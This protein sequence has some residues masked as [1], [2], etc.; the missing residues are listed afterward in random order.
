MQSQ[1]AVFIAGIADEF[2]YAS[3][4][5]LFYLGPDGQ[6]EVVSP[7]SNMKGI[8]K[9]PLTGATAPDYINID[10]VDTTATSVFIDLET[11]I[12]GHL[13]LWRLSALYGAQLLGTANRLNSRPEILSDVGVLGN[14]S[15]FAYYDP[16]IPGEINELARLGPDGQVELVDI[17]PRVSGLQTLN[18]G[19]GHSN[20]RDFIEFAGRLWFV[21]DTARGGNQL[22]SIDSQGTVEPFDRDPA[23]ANIQPYF[24]L[25]ERSFV[26]NDELFLRPKTGTDSIAIDADGN[27]RKTPLLG[28]TRDEQ[29]F[30][31]HPDTQTVDFAGS[32][33]FAGTLIELDKNNRALLVDGDPETDGVQRLH[34]QE[35]VRLG[36]QLIGYDNGLDEIFSYTKANGAKVL[37]LGASVAGDPFVAASDFTVVGDLIYFAAGSGH[38]LS[39]TREQRELW[40]ITPDGLVEQVDTDPTTSGIQTIY[41]GTPSADPQNLVEQDGYLYFSAFSEFEGRELWTVTPKGQVRMVDFDPDTRGIQTFAPGAHDQSF[42]RTFIGNSDS[43][44]IEVGGEVFFAPWVSSFDLAPITG[45]T[46][47]V[48]RL[49]GTKAELLEFTDPAL[50]YVPVSSGEAVY[51]DTRKGL[52]DVPLFVDP[53]ERILGTK[54]GETLEGTAARDLI[55]AKAGNDRLQGRGGDD[56]LKGGSGRDVALGG[57]GK[58]ILYGDGGADTLK[59]GRGNDILIGG[60]GEDLLIGNGGA[61]SFVFA[62]PGDSRTKTPDEIRGFRRGEDVIDIS[63]MDANPKRAG[64][65][66]FDFI[67]KATFT[68]TAGE[69]RFA[70]GKLALDIDGDGAPDV[71]ILVEGLA[72]LGA[73]D[74][75]L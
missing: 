63:G 60:A 72:R 73:S 18:T 25:M 59:G 75:I 48:Y 47:G 22:Y 28:S 16:D 19:G 10:I 23:V 39:P 65:Q 61:D 1:S 53:P 7:T 3:K 66:A 2:F 37:E 8:D 68:E 12:G 69:A 67:G 55:L 9:V 13:G 54:K 6:L 71:A 58:D 20:P 27:I 51:Y 38:I 62:R 31:P 44:W 52:L 43:M 4:N 14:T 46:S 33:Y 41:P 35:I 57:A 74:F 56:T 40:R 15:Y 45:I 50:P 26:R 42:Y 24:A 70:K 11:I 34:A 5:R 21:A 64:D 30:P 17:D 32:T 29:F 36:K 49:N